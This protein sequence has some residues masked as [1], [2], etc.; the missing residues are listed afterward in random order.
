M[1]S[2]KTNSL[3]EKLKQTTRP[4]HDAT[5]AVAF[6]KEMKEGTLS[7]ANYQQLLTSNL[8]IHQSLETAFAK[9]LAEMTA[10]PL[11]DFV[12]N[13]SNWL[14]KDMLSAAIPFKKSKFTAVIPPTYTNVAGLVGGLYVVEGSMLGG[15]FI[16]KLLQKSPALSSL[17]SFH[18]YSGYGQLTG[19]RWKA[20]QD[21]A[22]TALS[23]QQEFE[24]AIEKAKVTFAFFQEVY[25][26]HAV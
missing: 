25:K 16:V 11:A 14:E 4:M 13:K 26:T 21:L 19:Q 9:G 6:S 24:T 20:F 10:H 17:S 23:T 8:Y 12:D 22:T 5:E 1:S 7:L 3:L 2:T 18:F 15:R